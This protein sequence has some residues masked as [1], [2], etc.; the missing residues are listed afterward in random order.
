MAVEV[1]NVERNDRPPSHRSESHQAN[2]DSD[3]ARTAKR[4]EE[5]P[6]LTSRKHVC[7]KPKPITRSRETEKYRD[8]DEENKAKIE[9]TPLLYE[10]KARLC[11]EDISREHKDVNCVE[12]KTWSE[13]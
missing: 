5:K 7:P 1:T 3:G 8:R 11:C 2:G 12:K 13:T 6:R 4:E 9:R 10:V